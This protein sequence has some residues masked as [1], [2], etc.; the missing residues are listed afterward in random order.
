MHI[1]HVRKAREG[2]RFQM[3]TRRYGSLHFGVVVVD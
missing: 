3:K 1:S 2:V